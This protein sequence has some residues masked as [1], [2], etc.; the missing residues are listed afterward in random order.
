MDLN[1][2]FKIY[3]GFISSFWDGVDIRK[4]WLNAMLE[5]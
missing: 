3:L 5:K 1:W 4:N 2:R